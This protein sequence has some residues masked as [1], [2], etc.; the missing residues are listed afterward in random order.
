MSA[1]N[2]KI[3]TLINQKEK[4]LIKSSE[5]H[6]HTQ[7][8]GFCNLFLQKFN[9]AKFILL[10]GPSCSGKTTSSR[11]IKKQFL[12]HKIKTTAISLDDFFI[13]RD[14]TPLLPNG[15]KDYDSPKSI[16]WDLFHKCMGELINNKKS[17][18]PTYDFKKGLKTI[19]KSYTTLKSDEVIIIEGLHALNPE[20]HKSIPKKLSI[21]I[22]VSPLQ[23][24]FLDSVQKISYIDLRFMRRLIRDI[25]CRGISVENTYKKWKDVRDA[26]TKYIMPYKKNANFFIDTTHASEPFLYRPVLKE[27]LVNSNDKRLEILIKKTD[28]FYTIDKKKLPQ[29]SLLKEFVG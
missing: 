24:F 16:D 8:Q 12:E 7:V 25:R 6:Y 27:L 1:E 23:S 11:L 22:F 17:K 18:L 3:K 4:I 29:T 20:L 26:E 9:D 13:D 19:S 21:Q 28:L 15:E 5:S 2:Y 14:L 10:A